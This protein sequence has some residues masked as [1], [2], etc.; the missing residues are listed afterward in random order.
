MAFFPGDNVT[1]A[2][3]PG[4]FLS[5]GCPSLLVIMWSTLLNTDSSLSRRQCHFSFDLYYR[6]RFSFADR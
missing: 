4:F 3:Y 2:L 1:G 5:V 6:F